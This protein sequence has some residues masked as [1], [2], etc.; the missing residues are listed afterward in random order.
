MKTL[1][2]GKIYGAEDMERQLARYSAAA[3]EFEKLYSEK[4]AFFFSAPGRTEVGGNH[5]DHN[6]GCVLAGGVSLDIIAAVVPT[7]DGKITIKSEGFPV[8]TIEVE[9]TEVKEN[10]KNTSA[11]LIRGMVGGFKKNGHKVGGFKAYSTSEVLQGSGL[12][13]SAAYEVLIGT[14]LNGLYNN[15]EVSDVEVAKLAQYAENVYFGKPSGLMDQM[16]SSVGGL[17]T[18]DFADK[19]EPVINKVDFDFASSGHKLCIIDTKGSHADL[20][21][22]Y[23]AIP[24]E[25]KSVAEHFGKTVLREIDRDMVMENIA[26]LRKECGDRAVLRALH[27]FD[28]NERVAGQSAALEKG[29]FARFLE[30]ITESGQ[31]SLAY[32]QNIFAAVNVREQGLTVA[33]YL[34]K[35]LLDG[36]GACR[37]HG[38]GFA[39]TIQAFVPES[40]LE[41]FRAEMDR[42]FG[43]GSC[44][45]LSIRNCGG[46]KVL[47]EA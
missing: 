11:S 6:L 20:T 23:A 34:A 21:P 27:F 14:I 22:E 42:V 5:T 40:K 19:D 28:E 29:D 4:P 47:F 33:L 3:A 38:G 10:E 26:V 12:S 41:T 17:I 30:L 31:S 1:S 7:V 18:I 35:K 13:S 39:G 9:D 15:G 44:H 32:L 37:V 16:A 46:T 43:E 36:E 2:M 8:D 24:P 45:V 25:M